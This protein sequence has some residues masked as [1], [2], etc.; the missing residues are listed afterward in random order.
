M[1]WP[2]SVIGGLLLGGVSLLPYFGTAGIAHVLGN[3]AAIWLACAYAAGARS[4]SYVR[5]A[6]A[7]IVLLMAT[8]TTF[9]A[10]T[11]WLYPANSGLASE[12]AFGDAL[13]LIPA[14]CGGSAFGALGWLW[15][16]HRPILQALASCALGAAFVAEAA[17]YGYAAAG[18]GSTASMVVSAVEAAFGIALSFFLARGRL[19]RRAVPW[20]LPLLAGIA[21]LALFVAFHL[22]GGLAGTL[23]PA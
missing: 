17:L 10:G 8:L 9:F 11:H 1:L 19:A 2:A 21:F 12:I 6:V 20:L 4:G 3:S 18:F 5:G 23:H 13:W 7:G 14:V 16:S 15:R 22:V